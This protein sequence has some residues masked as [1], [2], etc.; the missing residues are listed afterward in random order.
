MP[1]GVNANSLELVSVVLAQEHTP[2]SMRG[3]IGDVNLITA[4]DM[5][6]RN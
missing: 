4:N 3:G 5:I 2:A 1:F 6:P